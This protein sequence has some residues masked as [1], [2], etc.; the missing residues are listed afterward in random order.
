MKTLAVKILARCWDDEYESARTALLGTLNSSSVMPPEVKEFNYA[1]ARKHVAMAVHIL[2]ANKPECGDD[3]FLPLLRV[4][5]QR[6]LGTLQ[7]KMAAAGDGVEKDYCRSEQAAW[8]IVL[9]AIS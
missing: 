8:E 6:E 1:S 3:L 5:C 2:V 7:D 9:H 4:R